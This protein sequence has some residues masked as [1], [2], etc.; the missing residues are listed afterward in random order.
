MEVAKLQRVW[1]ILM[2][3]LCWACGLSWLCV[4][5]V[6]PVALNMELRWLMTPLV[7]GASCML[8]LWL[9][10]C[11]VYWLVCGV[12]W[13][14]CAFRGRVWRFERLLAVVS[15]LIF[16]GGYKGIGT[17]V[18]YALCLGSCSSVSVEPT[19]HVSLAQ[20]CFMRLTD[21]WSNGRFGM[22]LVASE[23]EFHQNYYPVVEEGSCRI[24]FDAG[25]GEHAHF[26][27][28]FT[29]ALPDASDASSLEICFAEDSP[30]L[31]IAVRPELDRGNSDAEAVWQSG[32]A[33]QQWCESQGYL[34]LPVHAGKPL[35]LP[36]MDGEVAFEV[37]YPITWYS[38]VADR[39]AP[40][41]SVYFDVSRIK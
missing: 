5:C 37:V 18:R 30:A 28:E 22:R 1:K 29:L 35:E 13:Q 9:V 15:L 20:K 21:D 32:H 7:L 39:R 17:P 26:C 24:S 10:S 41:T 23:V 14:V 31:G 27:D 34:W 40:Y 16:L 11:G 19:W 4:F 33:P 38:D 3:G 8:V 6:L 36:V 12:Y 25:N 2:R